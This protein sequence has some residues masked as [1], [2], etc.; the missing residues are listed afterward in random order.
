MEMSE[1]FWTFFITTVAGMGMVGLRLCYKSK[2]RKVSCCGL[3]IE[4][5]IDI[6]MREDLEE[7]K[8]GELKQSTL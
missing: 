3:E 2:C 8:K 6:E 1:V 4:R 5:D 7:M